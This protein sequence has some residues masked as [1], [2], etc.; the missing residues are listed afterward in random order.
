MPSQTHRDYQNI[1]ARKIYE[2]ALVA[3]RSGPATIIVRQPAWPE[4]ES[5]QIEIAFPGVFL[6]DGA[7]LDSY[8]PNFNGDLSSYPFIF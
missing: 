2:Y 6:D 4:S 5:S 8:S 3:F 7:F 1:L